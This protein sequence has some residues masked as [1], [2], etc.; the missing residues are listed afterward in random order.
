VEKVEKGK[1]G[2]KKTPVSSSFPEAMERNCRRKS[3]PTG[4]KGV[5]DQ[6]NLQ[7]GRKGVECA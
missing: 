2:G 4:L 7:T 6:K 3:F 5:T 1:K